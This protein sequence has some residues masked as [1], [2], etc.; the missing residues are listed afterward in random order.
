MFEKNRGGN[1]IPI[2]LAGMMGVMRLRC[3]YRLDEFAEAIQIF[4]GTLFRV[5]AVSGLLGGLLTLGYGVAV[6][7]AAPG[8]WL[9]YGL[10]ATGVLVGVVLLRLPARLTARAWARHADLREQRTLILDESGITLRTDKGQKQMPWPE[11]ARV[12]ETKQIYVFRQQ[13]DFL[14]IIPR[15]VLESAKSREDFERLLAEKAGGKRKRVRTTGGW[16][17]PGQKGK[18]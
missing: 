12:Y 7:L 8:Y 5:M 16:L 9:G 2:P 4:R 14:Y 13:D 1:L 3:F 18:G 11:L 10:A 15:R 6:I 17:A